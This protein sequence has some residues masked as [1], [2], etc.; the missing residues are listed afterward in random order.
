MKI[1][2][3]P[4]SVPDLKLIRPARIG[5]SRGWFSEVFNRA[6]LE[7]HGVRFDPVQENLAFSAE[8]NVVR[9]LHAQAPDSAQAKLVRAAKGRIFDVAVDARA[10]SPTYGQWAGAELTA[11]GGEMLFAP[12][13]F[14]HGY[15]TRVPGCEVAYL[16]DGPYD[17]ARE[18]RVAWNDPDLGIA[19]G[20]DPAN[21]ILSDADRKAEAW[22]AFR[23]P[24]R[25]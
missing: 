10:G 20:V 23:T 18:I 21:A 19:W 3:T 9:G 15:A 12:R 2:V 14:L 4:L 17:A 5:D 13:G 24:F 11:E 6:E 22:A 8:P 25:I 16:V 1:D 7:K